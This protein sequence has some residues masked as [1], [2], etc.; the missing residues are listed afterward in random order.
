MQF[1]LDS[2]LL[3]KDLDQESVSRAQAAVLLVEPFYG[4]SHKQLVD[5]LAREIPGCLLCCLPA[6]KWHWR[7]RTSALYLSQ[8]IPRGGSF[9]VLFASSVLNLAELVALRTDLAPLKKLL[10][11][12]ENQ[13]IYPVRKQ[14]D[15]D[16]QYGYNQILSCQIS[17]ALPMKDSYTQGEKS[18]TNHEQEHFTEETTITKISPVEMDL[19]PSS[20]LELSRPLHIVWA[21]RWE[22]DKGPDLFFHVLYQLADQA[23]HF[24]VSVV[25]Q[26][27]TEVPGVFHE[28]Y[29]R[30]SDHILHWGYQQTRQEYIAVLKTADVAVSTAEHEFFGVSMLEAV[31]Y[32]CYPL[33]P[34]KLVYPEIFPSEYL[35]ST[36]QQL[37]KK[38]RYFCRNPQHVRARRLTVDWRRF[39][40]DKLKRQYFEIFSPQETKTDQN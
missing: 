10:Y 4:G 32:E 8:K 30:I 39:C 20:V 36:P 16:F 15:R 14:Q 37:L 12:H 38:L 25:G 26:T 2:D 18:V 3:K 19:C 6:K 11:F 23:L 35:Y 1:V 24:K 34:N 33:C 13:L 28:A 5:L 7:M 21:H 9:K 29:T 31:Q 27:F 17:E 40:W 22:H